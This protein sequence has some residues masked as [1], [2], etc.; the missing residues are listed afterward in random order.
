MA[1]S[2]LDKYVR[3]R[4]PDLPESKDKYLQE[5]LRKLERQSA[6]NYEKVLL[7]DESVSG[8]AAEIATERSVRASQTEALAQQIET[9]SVTSSRQNA[10]YQATAPQGAI[11]GDLWIDSDDGNKLYTYNSGAWV[12]I[13]NAQLALNAAAITTEQTAR[14]NADSSL[15]S[16]INTVSATASRLRVFRQGTAP[17]SPMLGD[18]WIDTA[19]NNRFKYWSGSAWVISD[20]LR[21]AVNAAAITNEQT[22]RANADSALA[23][24]IS[25]LSATTDTAL[26]NVNARITTEETVRSNADTALSS[27]ITN[28]SAV[29]NAKVRTYFQSTAPTGS[30]TAG[31]MWFKSDDNNKAFRYSGTAWVA[32]D[33]ARIAVNAAA[34]S[35]EST[36]R[37]NADSSLASQITTLSATTSTGL[38]SVNAR[39]STEESVRA[40]ADNSLA[41]QISSLTTTLN[42][43]TTS[44][45]SLQSSV[46]GVTGRYGVTINN[47]GHV[48]GI[49]LLSDSSNGN[50]SSV[51]RIAAD[52]FAIRNPGA[53]TDSIF[54]NGPAGR[55]VV[56]GDIEATSVTAGSVNQTGLATNAVSTVKIEANAVSFTAAATATGS[57]AN[58]TVSLQA[59]DKVIVLTT[60]G[61]SDE[62]GSTNSNINRTASLLVNGSTL[63]SLGYR[64]TLI[65]GF[66]S[67]FPTAT[68]NTEYTIPSSGSYTFT[69]NYVGGGTSTGGTS[70]VVL[71][72]KR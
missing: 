36:A 14:I 42:G 24:Q 35:T 22:A 3:G 26:N 48:S 60:V 33:D 40:S 13:D 25:T 51:F 32:V 43:N 2:N 71:G 1:T 50:P 52:Q 66:T 21:V 69:L 63:R 20:D 4:L 59:G 45:S 27:Q 47:N 6:T 53:S 37:A 46:N 23:T 57:G 39:I 17:S 65:T 61:V 41:S 5:E 72:L 56:R 19:D 8:L 55:L 44:I 64:A 12:P 11:Q 62:F 30:L 31:D 54:W 68:L 58:V 9:I 70:V 34:I 10:F 16:Q 7:T 18:L 49:S 29:A 15:A 67:S 28:V 38:T